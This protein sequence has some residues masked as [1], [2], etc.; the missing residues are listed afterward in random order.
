[1]SHQPTDAAS[2][3]PIRRLAERNS[4]FER[5]GYLIRLMDSHGNDDL[6]RDAGEAID[7]LL[8]ENAQLRGIIADIYWMARRYADGRSTYAPST[9]N[10]AIRRAVA[11]DCHLAVTAEGLF[12]SDGSARADAA[13]LTEE[14][15]AVAVGS[16]DYHR[17][18][19]TVPQSA[20]PE[21]TGP[22]QKFILQHEFDD[23]PSYIVP[24][25]DPEA[26]PIVTIAPGNHAIAR[27]V[28]AVI[29]ST[30]PA[31]THDPRRYEALQSV[32]GYW[33]VDL[34]DET[35]GTTIIG[36]PDLPLTEPLARTIADALTVAARNAR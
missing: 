6:Q 8:A 34:R 23:E 31:A 15:N 32:R 21:T 4:K 2:Q 19:A 36:G 26:E 17:F 7:A 30:S 35:G 24:A 12:A 20:D 13:G 11:L 16:S 29:Q 27:R 25:G 33:Y 1:M 22:I 9:Y 10:G 3:T 18:L 5:A 14:E 28:L